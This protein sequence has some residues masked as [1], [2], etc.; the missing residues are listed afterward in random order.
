MRNKQDR[1]TLSLNYKKEIKKKNYKSFDC[2]CLSIKDTQIYTLFSSLNIQ[3][4]WISFSE[5]R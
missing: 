2:S 1:L 5:N 3:I 4:P